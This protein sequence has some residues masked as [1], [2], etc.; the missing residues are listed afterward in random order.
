M[1]NTAKNKPTEFLLIVNMVQLIKEIG[2]Q[3]H[4][5]CPRH[6]EN[7]L[8]IDLFPLTYFHKVGTALAGCSCVKQH[9]VPAVTIDERFSSYFFLNYFL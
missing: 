4:K 3:I 5:F 8:C 6:I 1:G 2:P 9:I 7:T